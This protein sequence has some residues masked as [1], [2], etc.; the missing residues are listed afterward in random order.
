MRLRFFADVAHIGVCISPPCPLQECVENTPRS[1]SKVGPA[2]AN[3]SMV[4]YPSSTS[5]RFAYVACV[6]R[7]AVASPFCQFARRLL[8][9]I[10]ISYWACWLSGTSLFKPLIAVVLWLLARVMQTSA[11]LSSVT[12]SLLLFRIAPMHSLWSYKPSINCLTYFIA[13]SVRHY[14]NIL[15][16]RVSQ[17]K[18]KQT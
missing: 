17:F 5:P 16:I 6:A 2:E 1:N 18:S 8:C 9:A 11:R 4:I 3:D 7:F 15:L 14:C 12:P 13:I 10:P